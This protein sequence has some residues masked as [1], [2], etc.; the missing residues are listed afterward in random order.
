[1]GIV[2]VLRAW[3]PLR[4]CH[5]QQ[6]PQILPHG[7]RSQGGWGSGSE[8]SPVDNHQFKRGREDT[9]FGMAWCPSNKNTLDEFKEDC[10]F[11]ADR[12]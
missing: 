11:R 5:S 6:R 3:P 4:S 1:M 8:L 12:I 10:E 9:Q 7:P 2:G